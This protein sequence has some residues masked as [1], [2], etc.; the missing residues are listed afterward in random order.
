MTFYS[1]QF[2]VFVAALWTLCRLAPVRR[3]WAVLLAGS[4]IFY[5]AMGISGLMVL[6]AVSLSTYIFGRWLLVEGG[7]A[8]LAACVAVQLAILF[9]YKYL[10]GAASAVGISFYVFQSI[11]YLADIYLGKR[12]AERHLGRLFLYLSFFPKVLQGPIE[13]ADDLLPQ[14]GSIPDAGADEIWSGIR[15]IVIGLF[16]KVVIADQLAL[17]SDAAFGP[18]G[19]HAGLASMIGIYAFTLQIY[20]DFAGYT[21]CARGIA[22][23]FGLRL[24]E[25]FDSPY[26]A[27][28]IQ[29][30]WRRWHMTFSFWLRDYL[31]LP[32]AARFRDFGSLGLVA[33]ALVTFVLCGLWHGAAA[34][35]LVF[36]LL[37]GVYMAASIVTLKRRDRFIKELGLDPNL[38]LWFRR[39]VTFHLVVFAFVF[40]RA[41]SPA[42][43]FQLLRSLA[44]APQASSI[45]GAL[46]AAQAALLCALLGVQC[47]PGLL[48][49]VEQ[50]WPA[51]AYAVLING[52]I[53]FR[54]RSDVHFIYFK[55]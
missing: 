2:W 20:F 43:A 21:D 31:F 9:R 47:L 26:L 7:T 22:R 17:L 36:G 54:A 18:N 40:F 11:S 35:Y 15:L 46:S 42:Q 53:F 23:I 29:D 32:L 28:N 33:A 5:S 48:K 41:D 38:V 30:F 51:L 8:A 44:H 52:V 55:F 39:A 25:N 10:P 16:K 14:L 3:R 34:G 13:R 50:R 1:L 49:R 4:I 6:T 19:G 24:S 37:H 27:A 12:P 45:V